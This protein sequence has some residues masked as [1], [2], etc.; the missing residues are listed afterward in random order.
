[1]VIKMMIILS[2]K[3]KCFKSPKPFV[4]LCFQ[5]TMDDAED[6]IS[7]SRSDA[8]SSC[9][10]TELTLLRE[11]EELTDFTITS[12]SRSFRCHRLMLAASSPV[13][14]AMLRSQMSET[15]KEAMT[16]DEISGDVIQIILNYMYTGQI[17][18]PVSHLFDVLEA[19]NF[20]QMLEL[21]KICMKEA[22]M[23]L[24]PHDILQFFTIAD[25]MGSKEMTSQCWV[26]LSS[27]FIEVTRGSEFMNLPHSEVAKH[28]KNVKDVPADNILEAVLN[29]GKHAEQKILASGDGVAN[30]SI[31]SLSSRLLELLHLVPLEDCSFG[32]LDSVTLQYLDLFSVS[33]SIH[34][35]VSAAMVAVE[36]K[37]CEKS[38]VVLGGNSIAPN[39]TCWNLNRSEQFTPL[40]EIPAENCRMR[41]S[42][43]ETSRGFILSG[44]EGC[45]RCVMYQFMGG[46]W[47]WID[48]PA[49]PTKRHGHGSVFH[50]RL[51]WVFGGWVGGEGTYDESDQSPSVQFLDTDTSVWSDGPVLPN[52]V[53]YPEVARIRNTIYLLEPQSN[54]LLR[55]GVRRE[56]WEEAA[57]LPG[58]CAW[59]ARMIRVKRQLI[60]AGG[61][62]RLLALYSHDTDQWTT[63][64]PQP[65]LDHYLGALVHSKGMLY[66]IG[67][68]WH[69]KVEAYD[70]HSSTASGSNSI[71]G[72]GSVAGPGSNSEWQTCSFT[73]PKCLANLFSLTLEI[74]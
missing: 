3:K 65:L 71:S 54:R 69:D 64:G 63:H 59:G 53:S 22:S 61:N 20:L 13:L 35:L 26:K 72:S 24:A 29:W 21:K 48:L 4:L 1:M 46:A 52:A 37:E 56:V 6:N 9:L 58:A 7:V 66:L 38:I 27:C 8:Y 74:E 5:L 44:G 2:V 57:P 47:K 42:F 11:E 15:I 18:I 17:N 31:S 36:E 16:L 43:C 28:L 70:M 49:M 23:R 33:P 10:A 14:K 40:A 68:L 34:D 12:G 25:R 55:L 45:D 51:L 73:V 30:S 39:S 19:A 32:F 50:H 67:G 41:N 62:N 60:V